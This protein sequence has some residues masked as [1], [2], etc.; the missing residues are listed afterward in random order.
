MTAVIQMR[1]EGQYTNKDLEKLL[2]ELREVI[3]Q[4]EVMHSQEAAKFL[5]I[6]VGKLYRMSNIP[7]HRVEGIGGKLFLRSE[8]I[9][10]IKRH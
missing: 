2:I 7:H 5:G 6:S 10:F 1:P 8:L 9:D 3:Q 4:Q